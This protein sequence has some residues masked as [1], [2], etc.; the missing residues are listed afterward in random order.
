[1]TTEDRQYI[2]SNSPRVFA[3]TAEDF[4]WERRE[5]L[6]KL[7]RTI[8]DIVQETFSSDGSR[9]EQAKEAGEKLKKYAAISPHRLA[10]IMNEALKEG[11]RYSGVGGVQKKS[12][13]FSPK[14]LCYGQL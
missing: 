6:E 9:S 14:F 5:E 3:Q 11:K 7:S 4:T 1:M 13:T 2:L 10:Q 12:F 8:G